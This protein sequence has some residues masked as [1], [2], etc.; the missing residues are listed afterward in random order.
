MKIGIFDPYLDDLGG[1][2]KYMMTIAQ[3]LSKEHDVV[4][5]WD[6]RDDLKE[7][8]ERFLLD[9]SS[10]ELAKNIFAPKVSLFE[11]LLITKNF[12]ALFI[13]C[14]GSIPLVLSKMLFLHLQQ[15][16]AHISSLSTI[17]RLKLGRVS[18]IFCNSKFTKSFIDKTFQISSKVVY[19]PVELYPKKIKK[20]NI[21]LH[22]GRLRVRDITIDG[23]PV[24]DIKKQ[25]VLIDIFKQMV[26][27]GLQDWKFVLAVSVKGEDRQVLALIEK[28]AKGYPIE[29]VVNNNNKL[30]WNV[31]N[32]AQIYWHATGYG[33][34]V[35]IHP[36][37]TEHFGIS[38]VEAMGAGAV[39]VVINAGGQKEIV[40]DGKTG[41]LWDTL[42]EL[43]GK[44]RLLMS[45]AKRMIQMSEAAKQRA[46][47]FTKLGF[48]KAIYELLET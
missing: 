6:N 47:S 36:E 21:I 2:E 28:Q 19:P 45:D 24:G 42:D 18:A 27:S 23:N 32:R 26:D 12:D 44:T 40:E 16:M 8:A 48:C 46:K 25:S 33:E 22:V 41:F 37:Y 5:F 10:I 34:D 31:Y 29:F 1:G 30:L 7:L 9:L 11:R 4:V 15:P 39:P 13:L 17:E 20:E 43:Q 38:T 35:Q 14:D 3:C